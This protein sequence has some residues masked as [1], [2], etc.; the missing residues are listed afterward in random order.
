MLH[1]V[2]H[3][4]NEK[5]RDTIAAS[6]NGPNRK[7]YHHQALPP[8]GRAAAGLSSLLRGRSPASPLEDGLAVSHRTT[9]RRVSHVT[10]QSCSQCSAKGMK[11]PVREKHLQAEF[12]GSFSHDPQT[13]SGRDAL[14][15]VNGLTVTSRQWNVIQ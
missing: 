1:I 8:R 11:T 3:E 13:G 6:W 2:C 15:W 12:T 4:G 5:K 7:R 14:R 10:Q 9:L